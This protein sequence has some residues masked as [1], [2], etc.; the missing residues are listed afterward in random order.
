MAIFSIEDFEQNTP[1]TIESARVLPNGVEIHVTVFNP[2]DSD[3]YICTV[4]VCLPTSTAAEPQY[5][6]VGSFATLDAAVDAANA[7]AEG[8][9]SEKPQAIFG[10]L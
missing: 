4:A 5:A 10:S 3:K 1:R 6:K 2:A 8:A 9:A 7:I